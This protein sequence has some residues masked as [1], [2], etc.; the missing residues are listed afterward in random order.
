GRVTVLGRRRVERTRLCFV[1]ES[2]TDDRLVEGLSETFEVTVL[3]R[4]IEGGRAINHQPAIAAATIV[5]APSRQRFGAVIMKYL[6]QLRRRIDL[7][8]VEGYGLAA[9]ATNL[10]SRVTGIP[11]VMLVCSPAE[12]YYRCRKLNPEPGKSFKHGELLGIQLL[13]RAN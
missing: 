8:M 5:G 7:V 10:A 4:R 12:A 2:G 9:L 13:A 1:V 11:A 3:A 6:L